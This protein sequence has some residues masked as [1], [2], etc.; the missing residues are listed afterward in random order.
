MNYCFAQKQVGKRKFIKEKVESA[1]VFFPEKTDAP[2]KIL[3]KPRAAYPQPENGTVCFQGTVALRVQ[4][5]ATGEIGEIKIVNGLP[6]GANE[7][8]IDAAKR[9]KFEPA[10]KDGKPVTVFRVVQFSY[11]IY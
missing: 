7:N 5:L 6:F 1:E 8:A 3:Y 10:I 9:I 4:F 2:L 11:K